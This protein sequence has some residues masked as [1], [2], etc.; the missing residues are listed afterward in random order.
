MEA[1]IAMGKYKKLAG[2]SVVFAAGNLG[3]KMISFILVPL[4][5]YYLTTTEY[6][7]VDL[8][9]TTTSLLLP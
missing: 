9:T 6:G 4:Y 1:L 3:S 5:T 7:I 2:N 8:V